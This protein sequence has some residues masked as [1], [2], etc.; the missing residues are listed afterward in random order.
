MGVLETCRLASPAVGDDQQVGSQITQLEARG[1]RNGP[2]KHTHD[3]LQQIRLINC[4]MIAWYGEKGGI[5][6]VFFK[7]ELNTKN[8]IK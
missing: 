6:F 5:T 7:P 8:T 2:E 3:S 4:S 1:T